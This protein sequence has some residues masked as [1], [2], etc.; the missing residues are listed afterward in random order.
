MRAGRLDRR[1]TI[2]RNGA[3]VDDGFTMVPG[4]VETYAVRWAMWRPQTG[5][6]T[7]ESMGKEA[8]ASGTFTVRYDSVTANLKETDV[9]QYSGK[10]WNITSIIELGR[11]EGVELVVV[12]GEVNDLP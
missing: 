9:V 2:M 4:T 5:R 3:A 6:E 11:R 8:Y 7:H 10:L 12:S 1:I